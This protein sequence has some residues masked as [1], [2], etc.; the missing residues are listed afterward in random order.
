M[1]VYWVHN[2]FKK[3]ALAPRGVIKMSLDAEA[4]HA[5]TMTLTCPSSVTLYC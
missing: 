4:Q 3:N 2:G 1:R 5:S